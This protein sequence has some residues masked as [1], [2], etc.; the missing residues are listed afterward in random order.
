MVGS[1]PRSSGQLRRLAV[2]CGLAALL[3]ACGWFLGLDEGIGV[4][5]DASADATGTPSL[6]AGPD[7]TVDIGDGGP[8]PQT[9]DA[10]VS[11]FPV[12]ADGCTPDPSWCDTHCGQGA[13]N[14]GQMRQCPANCAAGYV[15]NASNTCDCQTESTWCNGRCGPTTDNCGKAINC[16]ACGPD[17]STCSPE[18]YL[19][20]CGSRQCGQTTN[21]CSQLVNCAAFGLSSRCL[22]PRQVCLSDGGCCSPNSASACGN[23]CGTFATDNCGQSVQCPSSCG[24]GGV[25]YQKSCCTPTNPCGGA[26][27]VTRVDNC[28]ET[29]KCGCSGGSECV[30]GTSTCC[31]PQGCGANCVDSCG[32]PA[33]SCC[34]DAGPETGPPEAGSVDAEPE[35]DLPDGGASAPE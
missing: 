14:C 2:V 9:A 32:L 23:Q 21:N 17:A 26:C 5:D 18:S 34:M 13:D 31:T 12:G 15:C 22:D 11:A 4:P 20:A 29:I 19:A 30:A 33:S 27:G 7:G 6:D 16:P 24:S 3:P 35:A 10:P 25:C 1:R 8:G 28:G